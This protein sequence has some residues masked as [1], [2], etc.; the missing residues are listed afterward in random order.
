VVA[1]RRFHVL[2]N[3]IWRIRLASELH[4]RLSGR[5]A[6]IGA[7]DQATQSRREAS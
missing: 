4:E 2:I 7:A 3:A 5:S 6:A 1:L